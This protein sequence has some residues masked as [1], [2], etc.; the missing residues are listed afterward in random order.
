MSGRVAHFFPVED[1]KDESEKP[2]SGLNIKVKLLD[3]LWGSLFAFLCTFY[4]VAFEDTGV[5]ALQANLQ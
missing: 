5:L 2:E 4:D 1:K 3:T